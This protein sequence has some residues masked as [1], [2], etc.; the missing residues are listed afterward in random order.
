MA[1]LPGEIQQMCPEFLWAARLSFPGP[2]L[3]LILNVGVCGGGV[4]AVFFTFF[5]FANCKIS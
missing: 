1:A 2:G 5:F 3:S 4:G